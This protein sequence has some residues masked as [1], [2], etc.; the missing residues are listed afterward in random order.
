MVQPSASAKIIMQVIP[1][2]W[3]QHVWV[4]HPNLPTLE[5]HIGV[6]GVAPVAMRF[7]LPNVNPPPLLGNVMTTPHPDDRHWRPT[8]G[9]VVLL[10]PTHS[11]IQCMM[12][13]RR[14]V[15][16]KGMI[17][18]RCKSMLLTALV[19][20]TKQR[21]WR[22]FASVKHDNDKVIHWVLLVWAGQ[23]KHFGSCLVNVWL[24]P[25]HA[26]PRLPHPFCTRPNIHTYAT[27]LNLHDAISFL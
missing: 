3:P 13:M 9:V 11:I 22:F 25:S 15:W 1:T 16:D 18:S 27:R 6:I 20:Q 2:R 17:L 5:V 19:Q 10:V 24:F 4:R 12:R 7:G 21:G 8:K 14:L 23:P 26:C